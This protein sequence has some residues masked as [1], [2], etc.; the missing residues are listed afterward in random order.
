MPLYEIWKKPST[1]F[2][3][4]SKLSVEYVP[5]ELPHREAQLTQLAEMFRSVVQSPGSVSIKVILTGPVGTGKTA[6]SKYFGIQLE[7]FSARESLGIRYVHVNCHKDRTLFL[8]M[9]HVTEQLNI[10]IPRRGFSSRELMNIL[11]SSLENKDQYLVLTIDEADYLV[12]SSGSEALYDLSRVLDE[13]I[14][15]KA[16]MSFIF[17]F[18]DISRLNL[19]EEGVRSS[20]MHNII[21]FNPYTSQEIIDILKGRVKEGALKPNALSDEALELIGELTGVDK[22]GRGDARQALEILWRAGKYAEREGAR[23]IATEHVRKAYSDI[24]PSLSSTILEALRTHELLLLLSIARVLRRIGRKEVGLGEVEREYRSICEQLGERPRG[25]TKVWEYT[26]NLSNI[27]LITT[28]I[29]GPGR[30]GKTTLIGVPSV[31]VEALEKEVSL[32]V[33]Q[34]IRAQRG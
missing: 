8:M 24:Y 21:R 1:I 4:E 30:R 11:W 33:K 14:R 9:K 31:P 3:D 32:R 27:G 6:V 20:L 12:L 23:F 17:V 2:E 7:R 13:Y 22:G 18:R 15:G 29:S 25:H 16:R 10:P 28:R 5:N 26:R 34:L 19:L